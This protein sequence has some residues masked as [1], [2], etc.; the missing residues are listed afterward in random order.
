MDA[1][2]RSIETAPK[3]RK[4]I[5]VYCEENKSS[6]AVC[7]DVYDGW[8][9]FGASGIQLVP[10][11]THWQPLPEPPESEATDAQD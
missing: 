10:K 2:W 11:P 3:G 1:N 5:L 9:V 7:W 4:A 8:R 6:Y